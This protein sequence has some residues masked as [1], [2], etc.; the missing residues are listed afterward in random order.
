MNDDVCKLSS[1]TDLMLCGGKA[2]ALARLMQAGFRIPNGFVVTT[3]KPQIPRKVIEKL[4]EELDS[5]YLAVRS[6]AV[7]EDGMENSWAGQL[8][9]FLNVTP[10]DVPSK[11]KLCQQS[12]NSQR[13]KAYAKNNSGTHQTAVIVQEMIQAEISGVAFSVHPVTQDTSSMVI[14]SVLGLGEALVSGSVTPDTYVISKKTLKPTE[15]NV[16]NQTKKLV[17]KKN[18]NTWQI[19]KNG[20]YQKLSNLDIEKISKLIIELEKFC[21][22]AID[23]E[24]AKWQDQFYVLQCR[25]ITTLT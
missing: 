15:I 22:F 18:T 5:P 7:M 8:E 17:L 25:P 24:W 9:T 4:C 10:V 3:K 23:V 13:A 2:S 1:A 12:V 6:S 20:H 21:G 16:G 14:E 11:I 19:I